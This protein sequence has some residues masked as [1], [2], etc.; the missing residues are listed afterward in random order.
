MPSSLLDNPN[1]SS[2]LLLP[3]FRMSSQPRQSEELTTCPAPTAAAAVRPAPGWWES[4]CWA[5]LYFVLALVM[6][7]LILLFTLE[8]WA[9]ISGHGRE[10]VQEVLPAFL[11]PTLFCGQLLGVALAVFA[12]R[13][14]VGRDWMSAIHL[15]RPALVPCLLAVLCLPAVKLL[16]GGAAVLVENLLNLSEPSHQM[17]TD[18]VAQHGLWFSL[19]TVAVGAAVAEEL[20]CRGFLGRGLVGR[21]GVLLGVLLTSFIFGLLH[22]N[23][24]QGV[25]AFLGGCYIHAVYLK[26]RSLWVPIL[27]HFLNNA[28]AVI[29]SA[30]LIQQGDAFEPDLDPFATWA[31][32]AIAGAVLVLAIPSAWGLYRWRDTRVSVEPVA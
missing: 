26:T 1:G 10:M 15:R 14:R 29:L 24:P 3:A 12:L 20:F 31:G 6:P 9:I 32:L 16:A 5:L 18:S 2:S 19:L 13:V 21:H 8:F 7:F 23:I 28:F 30:L 17:V 22:A 27:L 11:E 4:L 25:F